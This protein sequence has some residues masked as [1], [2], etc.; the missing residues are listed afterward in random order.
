MAAPETVR[1]KLSSE[2]AGAISLTPVVVRD[3]SLREL[4]EEIA[5]VHGKD[6]GRIAETLKRGSVT[7]G[8]TRFRWQCVELSEVELASALAFLPVDEPA[9]TFDLPHCTE[10]RLI[11][12][13]IHIVVSR[14]VADVRRLFR[15]TSFWSE[16]PR[17]AG[18]LQYTVYSYRE[19]ADIFRAP[20]S[21]EQREAVRALLP[22]LKHATLA[23]RIHLAPFDAIEFVVTR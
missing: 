14:Q 17:I 3:M 6:A 9:R 12:P 16:L 11:G 13:G 5:A 8:A 18:A 7:G 19:R 1:V 22:A 2:E 23:R 21:I 20:L 10:A 15:R 4:I